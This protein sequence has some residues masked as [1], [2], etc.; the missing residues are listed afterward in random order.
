MIFNLF[1][2][3][4]GDYGLSSLNPNFPLF[5]LCRV[6]ISCEEY[7]LLRRGFN[8]I[9][10]DIWQ[11]KN[12]IFHSRDIRKCEKEFKYLFDLTLKASFYQQLDNVITSRDYSIIA[13]A[14]KKGDYIKK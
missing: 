6:V 7:E 12:V 8:A 10:Q 1:I 11:S 9:K 4:S 5:L 3:E 14:I 2:D 13:S